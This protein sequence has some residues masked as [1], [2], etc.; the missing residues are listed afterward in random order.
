[1]LLIPLLRWHFLQEALPDP[2]L[3]CSLGFPCV[4]TFNS[5]L[6]QLLAGED[7]SLHITT[8]PQHGTWCAVGT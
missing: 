6:C 2:L 4:V 8:A 3:F 7:L 1:M 5:A